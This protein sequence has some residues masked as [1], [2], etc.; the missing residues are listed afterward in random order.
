MCSV[1]CRYLGEVVGLPCLLPG[2][3]VERELGLG[4]GEV[5]AGQQGVRPVD[6]AGQPVP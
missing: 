3:R 1:I 2:G 6:L 4:V 5:Q